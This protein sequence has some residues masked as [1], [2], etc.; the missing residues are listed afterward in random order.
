MSLEDTRAAA[1]RALH[2]HMGRAAT[3]YLASG[4][5]AGLVHVRVN[6]KPQKMGDLAGTNLSYAETQDYRTQVI[7]DTAEVRDLGATF[8]RNDFVVLAGDRGYVVDTSM[9]PDGMTTTCEVTRM[10][11]AEL[12]GKTLPGEL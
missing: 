5:I 2:D 4:V 10:S 9:P 3:Y 11:T 12:T 6:E 7:F 1:R 8:S